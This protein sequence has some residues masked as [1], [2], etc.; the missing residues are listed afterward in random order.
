[1]RVGLVIS[2]PE[3][4]AKYL[5]DVNDY[6]WEWSW[7]LRPGSYLLSDPLPVQY[8]RAMKATF[9]GILLAYPPLPGVSSKD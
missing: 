8:E 1:M 2:T 7:A 4:T 6:E 3:E 9:S 5:I